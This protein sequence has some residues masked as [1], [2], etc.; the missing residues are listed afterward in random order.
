ME[1]GQHSDYSYKDKS[2]L[3]SFQLR[4][5]ILMGELQPNLPGKSRKKKKRDFFQKHYP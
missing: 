1:F 4:E 3:C 5:F 2:E